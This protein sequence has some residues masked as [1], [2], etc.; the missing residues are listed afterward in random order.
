MDFFEEIRRNKLRVAILLGTLY[1]CL[2]L[3]FAVPFGFGGSPVGFAVLAL[4]VALVTS[5]YLLVTLSCSKGLTMAA[6]GA[7]PPQDAWRAE[8]EFANVVHEMALA[9][10]APMPTVVVVD[11]E[12]INAF[13]FGLSPTKTYVGVNTGTLARLTREE[14]QAV[15]AHEVGHLVARDTLLKSVAMSAL[16]VIDLLEKTLRTLAAGALGASAAAGSMAGGGK[17]GA[18][19]AG[20]AMFFLFIAAALFIML[21]P[22]MV[23]RFFAHLVFFAMSRRQEYRADAYAVQFTRNKEG[24][25]GAFQKMAEE[26]AS[27]VPATVASLRL[28]SRLD[29][30]GF[31]GAIYATHP[32]LEKRMAVV[33]GG[34]PVPPRPESSRLRMAAPRAPVAVVGPIASA[35]A[36]LERAD[37]VR[38]AVLCPRCKTKVPLAIPR[39]A[40][41]T[42]AV[43]CPECGLFANIAT[44]PLM[45]PA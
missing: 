15:V 1:L 33:N 36:Q 5:V 16:G 17:K 37:Q 14:L 34:Q 9:A 38:K 21:L 26:T 20:A 41:A 31:L 6:L 18:A 32:P 7:R 43:K 23:S 28:S 24:L 30:R 40:P 19:A 4:I 27:S 39:P 2:L 42:I 13:A 44:A 22:V 10:G 8:R 25:I 3:A 45:S 35:P 12:T 11:D 29:G